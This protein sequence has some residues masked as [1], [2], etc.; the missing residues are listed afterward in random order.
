MVVMPAITLLM[1]NCFSGGECKAKQEKAKS[2]ECHFL[3]I[4]F[5]PSFKKHDSCIEHRTS[6][7]WPGDV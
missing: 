4:I 5:A 2:A 1:M 7:Q 6:L 3:P